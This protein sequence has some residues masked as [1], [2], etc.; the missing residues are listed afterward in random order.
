MCLLIDVS[1]FLI[2]TLVDFLVSKQSL[3]S[4]ADVKH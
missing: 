4:V 1:F 2:I 3:K